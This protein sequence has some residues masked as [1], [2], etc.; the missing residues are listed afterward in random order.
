MRKK[1]INVLLIVQNASFPFD[2][3]ISKEADSL[4]KNGFNVFVISPLS[5]EDSEKR[6]IHNGIQVF[7]YKNYLSSGSIFGFIM[8][9]SFSVLKIMSYSMHLIIFKNISVVHV[10]NPPDFFWPIA[11]ICKL[12][13]V[14]FIYDQHDLSP[15][16]FKIRFQNKLIFKL[17]LLNEKLTVRFSDAIIVVNYSFR[18]RLEERWGLKN[19][20]CFVI[21]NGPE[22]NFNSLKNDSLIEQYKGKHIILYVGLMAV[23]DCIEVIV[24]AAEKIVN[25]YKRKDCCFIL[26]G[27][28]D[29]RGRLEKDVVNKGLSGYVKFMGLVDQKKVM[30]YLFI[31]DVCIAPDKPNGL[32]EYLT[33]IKIL[34]YMKVKK[35][36]VSFDLL[37]TKNIAQ[38]SGLYAKNIDD[39]V[40]KILFLIDNPARAMLLGERGY[41]IV[42]G[43]YLWK[44][45]EKTL[46]ELYNQ[47]LID[48]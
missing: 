22:E 37:E 44:N 38:D 6:L 48:E 42:Q 24:E 16:M 2:R 39:Y 46:L 15:E 23:T 7:R 30:E 8:E 47:L 13:K 40:S 12:F 1:N 21:Y 27:D 3:R 31:A 10:A 5:K 41:N 32:N 33:L 35:P 36:F 20:N 45:S 26:L 11:I 29:I 14:K 9:Y 25:E 19:K 28:G 17:L 34:E 18:K 4:K 43:N